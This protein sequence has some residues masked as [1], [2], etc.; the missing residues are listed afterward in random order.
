MAVGWCL[1]AEKAR[2]VWRKAEVAM[3]ARAG[4]NHSRVWRRISDPFEGCKERAKQDMVVFLKKKKKIDLDLLF[5]SY[6]G[7]IG[8]Q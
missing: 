4:G 1:V 5:M 6:P 3:S 2:R 7:S 8:L